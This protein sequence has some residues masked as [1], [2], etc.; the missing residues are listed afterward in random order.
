MVD[1]T[2][3]KSVTERCVGSSP[4]LGTK[5]GPIKMI[6]PVASEESI[7]KTAE[8]IKNS[9]YTNA[10]FSSDELVMASKDHFLALNIEKNEAF[11]EYTAKFCDHSSILTA[12]DNVINKQ[13]HAVMFDDINLVILSRDYYDYLT[14]LFYS[15]EEADHIHDHLTDVFCNQE[16]VENTAPIILKP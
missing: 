2:D 4:T 14:G 9:V 8:N 13:L 15:Q 1:A 16:D 11:K 10:M 7:L 5:K 6:K 12:V 3:S